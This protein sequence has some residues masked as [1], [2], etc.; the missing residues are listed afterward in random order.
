MKKVTRNEVD[1]SEVFN[2]AEKKFDIGWN[3][4]CDLFHSSEFFP[5][6]RYKDFHIDELDGY[7]EDWGAEYKR[8]AEILKA[9]MLENK[10]K[11]CRI[12]N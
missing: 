4:C 12:F 6:K 1:Y 3:N 9:F 5:Y 10:I 8:P 2:F 11:E 7:E